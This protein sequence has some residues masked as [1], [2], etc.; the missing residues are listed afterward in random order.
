MAWGSALTPGSSSLKTKKILCFTNI[1]FAKQRLSLEMGRVEMSP[2]AHFLF[3]HCDR[4]RSLSAASLPPFPPFGRRSLRGVQLLFLKQKSLCFTNVFFLQSKGYL[5]RWGELNSR[6]SRL[7]RCLYR[8]IEAR[9]LSGDG[10]G[11]KGVVSLLRIADCSASR[12]EPAHSARQVPI[13]DRILH[14]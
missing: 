1:F 8:F 5:W 2:F 12:A 4:L 11:F 3:A 9:Y 13:C 10:S 7:S 6:P 14:R